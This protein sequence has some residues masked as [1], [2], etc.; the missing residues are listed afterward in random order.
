MRVPR[1]LIAAGASGSGKTLITCGILQAL[2]SRG[3]K[4][5]SFK[6]GP[7]YIDPMFHSRVIG[8]K[9]RNLDTFFTDEETTRYLLEQN[10]K[11]TDISVI[12]GVMGYYDGLGGIDTKAS[13]YDVGKVTRT[14]VIFVVNTKGMSLSV[15]AY[16]KGFL[17]YKKDSRICGVILN[18]MSPMLYPEMKKRIEEELHIAVLGYV[19]KMENLFLE[20]RHLGLVMPQEI[21]SLNEKLTEFAQTLEQTLEIDRMLKIAEEAEELEEIDLEIPYLREQPVIA[22]ARDE[23]FCFVY[24]DNLELLKK[25]GAKLEE[26][27]PIHDKE[28]PEKAEGLL[29]YGGYPELAARELSENESMR[30]SIRQAIIGGMPCM[31]ECGGFMYLHETMEDMEGKPWSMAGVIEGRAYHTEKLGRFGYIEIEAK[32]DQIA[33]LDGGKIR[34]HEFHYFDSTSCGDFFHAQKPLRK[35]GWD[36]IHGEYRMIAGFPHLYYYSNRKIPMRFLEACIEFRKGK[37]V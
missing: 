27:S 15:L 3:K 35:R 33:G 1:F 20:S 5:S 28:L 7:D 25:M 11:G 16:L 18:Q 32:K 36:C 2:C 34:A 4:V 21:K 8:T 14:P 6:C 10:A 12:E 26:F 13:A 9:S 19:P 22:V 30:K 23:A 29:L 37:T 24:E 17:E 31:A